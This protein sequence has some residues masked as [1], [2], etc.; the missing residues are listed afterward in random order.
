MGPYTAT[1]INPRIM[2]PHAAYTL[3]Q[4]ANMLSAA[5][6]AARQWGRPIQLMGF[7]DVVIAA[8]AGE[9]RAPARRGYR[10]LGGSSETSGTLAKAEAWNESLPGEAGSIP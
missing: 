4:D 7:G 3:M 8:C 5:R 1:G 9:V 10:I 2:L 6:N